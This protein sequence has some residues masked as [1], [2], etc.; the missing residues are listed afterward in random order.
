MFGFIVAAASFAG[1]VV[2]ATRRHHGGYW[3]FRGRGLYRF[4]SHLGTTPGQEKV[5][6]TAMEEL[7]VASRQT[8]SST[9]D[10]RPELA[11]L[12]RAE[13]LDNAALHS[14]FDARHDNLRELELRIE[15]AMGQIHDVLDERQKKEVANWVER[16]PRFGF[17][18]HHC[19]RAC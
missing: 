15:R 7:R 17:G 4:L 14:W 16:G 11:E 13:R 8:W 6:R 5:I 10:A 9:R 12:I 2:L 18:H 3:G 19:A 1:L